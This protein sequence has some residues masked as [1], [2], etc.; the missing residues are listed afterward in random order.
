[1]CTCSIWVQGTV[2]LELLTQVPDLDAI[3]APVSGGGL[4]SGISIAAKAIKPDII[5]L[6]AEPTG[7]FLKKPQTCSLQHVAPSHMLKVLNLIIYQC[8]PLLPPE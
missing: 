1:M 5:I 4:I 2:G 6:A 8:S 3:I 7:Q